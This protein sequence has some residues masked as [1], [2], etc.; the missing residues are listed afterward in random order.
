M[1]E[2]TPRPWI[3]EED[4]HGNLLIVAPNIGTVAMPIGSPLSGDSYKANANLISASPDLLKALHECRK[5]MA[6]YNIPAGD[7]SWMLSQEAIE[8]AEGI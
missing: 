6:H 5:T 4:H 3:V 2:H 1:S 8:K 7:T